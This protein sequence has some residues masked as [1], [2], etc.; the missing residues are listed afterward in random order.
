M[1]IAARHVL[2]R[3]LPRRSG[4]SGRNAQATTCPALVRVLPRRRGGSLSRMGI[5]ARP[6][7]VRVL[8]RRQGRARA[9]MPKLLMIY[10]AVTL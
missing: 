5:P 8:Q 9:G 6:L 3:T 4:G 10:G 2:V 1:G 7:L